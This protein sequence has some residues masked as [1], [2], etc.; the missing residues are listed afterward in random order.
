M[1]HVEWPAV[2]AMVLCL[3]AVA[4]GADWPQ[5][6]GDSGRTGYTAEKLP[7]ELHRQRTYRASHP[8]Q[9]A[10]P[11]VYWQRQTYDLA[12]QPVVAG[13]TLFYASSAGGK[14]VALDAAT[15][16]ERWSFFTDGPLRFAPAAWKDRGFVAGDDGYLYCLAAGDGKLLCKKRGGLDDR[17]ILGNGRLV[18]RWP[19][20]GRP[21]RSGTSA[22]W[23]WCPPGDRAMAV[24]GMVFNSDLILDLNTGCTLCNKVADPATTVQ[25]RARPPD[26][27]IM[28]EAAASPERI[29][30]ATGLRSGRGPVTE[31]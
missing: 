18:S 5:Y 1:K 6:R 28:V 31:S 17:T 30:V 4:C 15:G 7:D 20:R 16:H 13:G 3:S 8:P 14:L 22:R 2:A 21:G 26:A 27:E 25:I 9:P 10:W 12:Y 11:D 19:A 29:F 23:S 24:D